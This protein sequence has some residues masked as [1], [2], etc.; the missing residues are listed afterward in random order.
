MVGL[1]TVAFSYTDRRPAVTT[2]H[3][4]RS[5][6]RT[7][8]SIPFHERERYGVGMHRS[9]SF[10][11]RVVRE[12]HV[13][14]CFEM[15]RAVLRCL[16]YHVVMEISNISVPTL[17]M[18]QTPRR[19]LYLLLHYVPVLTHFC[20]CRCYSRGVDVSY[21]I[22]ARG[23]R[24]TNHEQDQGHNTSQRSLILRFLNRIGS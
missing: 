11:V 1:I 19:V 20:S 13:L 10:A 12:P 14:H 16:L 4:A 8:D 9:W 15:C 22:F 21:R 18:A 7:T 24:L 3:N 2:S 6:N 23:D 5:R 17:V